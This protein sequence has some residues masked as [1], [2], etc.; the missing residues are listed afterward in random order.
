MNKKFSTDEFST[1]IDSTFEEVKKLVKLKGGEYSGDDDRLANFRRN[2]ATLDLDC[3]QVWAIYSSK[4]WD[5]IL[6]YIKDI[7]TG[8]ER[9]RLESIESRIDDL[10]TYL[11]LFKAMISE[12]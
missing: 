8:K 9:Q 10:I 1:L 11:L 7:K 2:A 5:S 6:Q 4:H 3:R 12:L